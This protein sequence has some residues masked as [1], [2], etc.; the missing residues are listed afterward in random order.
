MHS[1]YKK[2]Q[3]LTGDSEVTST[4]EIEGNKKYNWNPYTYRK[5]VSGKNDSTNYQ[6]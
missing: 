2:Q 5:L 1:R 6:Q 3:K 4:V